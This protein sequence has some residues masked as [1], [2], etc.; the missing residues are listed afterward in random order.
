M[1]RAPRPRK[2]L[3]VIDDLSSWAAAHVTA[4]QLATYWAVNPVSVQRWIRKGLLPA[5]RFGGVWRIETQDA[6]Q[7]ETGLFAAR[8]SA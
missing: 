5:K 3:P 8:E 7:F 1:P 6:L 2:P 4:Q